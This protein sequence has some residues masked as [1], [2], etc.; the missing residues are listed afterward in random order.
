MYIKTLEI[1][2][3]DEEIR[4]IEFHNGLNLIVDNTLTTSENKTKTGNNVGKTTILKLIDVCLGANSNIVYQD[5]E[6]KKNEYLLVKNFLVE[7]QVVI[8][9]TIVNSFTHNETIVI[10]RNFLKNKK[11][12]RRING[13]DVLEKDFEK[14]LMSIFFKNQKYEKPS[15]RQIISHNN[16]YTESK[17]A[18]TLK[19][20]DFAND[21]EYESLYLFL[22][23]CNVKHASEKQKLIDKKKQEENYKKRLENGKTKNVY[24]TLLRQIGKDIQQLDEKK[25]ALGLN[26]NF[27]EDFDQLN[28]VKYNINKISSEIT[29][30][31]VRKNLIEETTK[32][33][34]GDKSNINLLQL[35]EL[36]DEVK[37]NL[38]NIQKTFEEL[39]EYHNKMIVEKINFIGSELPELN[40]VI[41]QKQQI[42]TSLLAE[43]KELTQ[44]ISK[45]DSFETLED[46][47]SQLNEKY[48][49]KGECET[50]INQI[51]NVEKEIEI[52]VN[53][54]TL[55]NKDLFSD[56]FKTNVSEKIDHFNAFYSEISNELY[57]EKYILT[58]D[59]KSKNGK[60]IYDFNSFNTNMST[61]KKQGEILCFDL[62]Y[63]LYA[64]SEGIPCLDFLL[65][66][67]KELL[68]DNQLEKVADFV[69]RNNIQLVIPIL[70]DKLPN[71]LVNKQNIILELSQEDKLFRIEHQ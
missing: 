69:Y 70:K 48:H 25:T 18:N 47:I 17:I 34:E 30:L 23:G 4:K 60:K 68:H 42:L 49:Q 14:S 40:T 58:Y 36:Y 11:A 50:I 44:K 55:I 61:G 28:N 45:H 3:T 52:I 41:L 38:D 21:T 10:E 46:I 5:T 2:S 8:K 37:F 16:R 6:K 22:L 39:I 67:K 31:N 7:K 12:I 59:I 32:D 1:L 26:S 19:T 51:E 56:E 27:E 9:L 20:L 24:S 62:A 64:R 33:M 54:L 66:D 65:N 63:I 35:K 53:D 71:S 13:K 15:F 57:G 29:T 43:E